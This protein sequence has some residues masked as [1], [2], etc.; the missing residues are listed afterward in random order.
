M[1][2]PDGA[3]PEVIREMKEPDD[4]MPFHPRSFQ[5]RPKESAGSSGG[6][7]LTRQRPILQPR[8]APSPPEPKS[9]VSEPTTSSPPTE[10][11]P[12]TTSPAETVAPRSSE[13]KVFCEDSTMSCMSEWYASTWNSAFSGM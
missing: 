7:K 11:D 1:E 10:S 9:Q 4:S 5:K 3:P 13:L 2:Y 8:V 6:L 12:V